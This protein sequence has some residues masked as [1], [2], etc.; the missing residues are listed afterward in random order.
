MSMVR[1]PLLAVLIVSPALHAQSPSPFRAGSGHVVHLRTGERLTGQLLGLDADTL[2][3]RTTWGDKIELPR[4]A[5]AALTQVPGR[6]TLLDD[7]FRDGAKGWTVTGKPAVMAAVILAEPGQALTRVLPKP[8]AAGH[9]GVSF[10]ER[11]QPAG[12]RWLFEAAFQ[13]ERDP[14][15]LRVVV[16]GAGD[17]YRVETDGIA[18]TGRKVARSPGPHRL[19]VRFG[20]RSLAVLCDDDVLWH[21]LENGPGGPLRQVRLACLPGEKDEIVKGSVSWTEFALAAAVDEPRRPP[22]DAAQDEVWLADGDQLFGEVIRVDR[23]TVV[24]KGR[25][26]ERSVAWSGVRGCFFREAAIVPKRLEGDRVLIRLHAPF[27]GEPDV[28]FG[29]VKRRDDRALTLAHALLGEIVV[30]HRWV[31][32]VRK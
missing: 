20:P 16:A 4:Q 14:R 32:E 9:A 22:G 21:N 8:L 2:Q 7:D 3:L 27:G 13:G 25:F 29:V 23:R 28:L 19:T 18:G 1:G 6:I 5:V 15:R 10:A 24:L 30:E 12:G 31:K 26:G 17:L 11:D